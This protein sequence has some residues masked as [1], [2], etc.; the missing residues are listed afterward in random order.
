MLE[1]PRAPHCRSGDGAVV[2]AD[3]IHQAEIE[4]LDPVEGGDLPG[5]AKRAV[6]LD[7]HM[8]RDLPLDAVAF[9]SAPDALDLPGGI[10][11]AAHLGYRK[12]G[13]PAAGQAD[14]DVHV[15]LPVGVGDVVDARTDPAEAVVL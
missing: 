9:F 15:L 4:G 10:G 12:E 13:E 7:E 3:E 8:N 6:G 14:Q 5:F 2:A 11:G 1:L